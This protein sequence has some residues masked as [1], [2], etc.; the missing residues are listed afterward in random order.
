M[1]ETPTIHVE[2]EGSDQRSTLFFANGDSENLL[3]SQVG[4]DL[5][6]LE[7][8]SFLG[9]GYYHDVIRALVRSD[10]A[11]DVQEIVSRSGLTTLEWIL[12]KDVIESTELRSVL[13]WVM[14]IGGGWERAFSGVLLLHL[15]PD[16]ADAAASRIKGLFRRSTAR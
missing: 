4:A 15:P 3:V 12:S 7:E 1:A 6:R 16:F 5:F 10:G 9:E 8:S 14:N 11:L 13:D 2:Y